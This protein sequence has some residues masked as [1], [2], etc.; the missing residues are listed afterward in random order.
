MEVLL[1]CQ[2]SSTRIVISFYRYRLKPYNLQFKNRHISSRV[3]LVQPWKIVFFEQCIFADF[4][5]SVKISY[6]DILPQFELIIPV[7]GLVTLLVVFCYKGM[8]HPPC[9]ELCECMLIYSKF[10]NF[11]C[12]I[13]LI[14]VKCCIY[15]VDLFNVPS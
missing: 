11:V 8:P 1:V 3:P 4:G 2:T 9:R 7:C 14:C 10:T 13:Q 15:Q 6:C 5:Y 12:I